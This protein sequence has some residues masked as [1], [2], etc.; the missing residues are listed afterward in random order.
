MG[1]RRIAE[2]PPSGELFGEEAGDVVPRRKCDRSRVGLKCLNDH[3][4]GGV[5]PAAARE[6]RDELKYPLLGAKVGHRQP[7]VAVDDSGKRNTGK[8]VPLCN[9]LSA[10]QN[11]A[12]RASE[13][14]E[15]S[16]ESLGPGRRVGIEADAFERREAR[17]ELCFEPLGARPESDDFGRSTRRALFGS[18]LHV[19]A[20]VTPKLVS[21]DDE[22]HVAVGAA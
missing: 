22:R 6:L 8:V 4:A 10:E 17:S 9:H 5:A 18:R 19:S 13:A 7:D 2:R 21:V 20:V 1:E 14:S 15:R 11:R 16:G 3:A 12:F